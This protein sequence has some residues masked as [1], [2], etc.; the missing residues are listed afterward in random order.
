[1]TKLPFKFIPFGSVTENCS[2]YYRSAGDVMAAM[3]VVKNKSISFLWELNSV[4]MYT[5]LK[6]IKKCRID[7]QHGRHVTWHANQE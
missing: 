1:M 2:I 7:H 5:L 3:L 6:K 4:F